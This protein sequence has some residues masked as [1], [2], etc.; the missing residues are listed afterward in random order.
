MAILGSTRIMDVLLQELFHH[1]L[2]HDA[3]QGLTAR[4]NIEF[5]LL[6]FIIK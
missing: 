5:T 1:I 6:G 3:Y 2:E 4:R